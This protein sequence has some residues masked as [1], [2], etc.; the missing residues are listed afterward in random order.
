MFALED[1]TVPTAVVS[2]AAYVD[3]TAEGDDEN[4]GVFRFTRTGSTA[5]ALDVTVSFDGSADPGDDYT[6]DPDNATTVHFPIGAATADMKVYAPIDA[7][8]EDDETVVV[9]IEDY[10]PEEYEPDAEDDFATLIITDATPVITVTDT[11]DGA[12]G[13]ANG[14]FELTRTGDTSEELTVQYA[15]AGT[16]TATEGED[17]EVTGEVTFAASSATAE[18]EVVIIDDTMCDPDETAQLFISMGSN[19]AVG[20]PADD[21]ITITDD[22]IDSMF[23]P[24]HWVYW[25]GASSDV[26]SDGDNWLTGD[27]KNRVPG[28]GDVAVFDK[29]YIDE[30]GS[31]NCV[32]LEG[33]ISEVRITGGYEGTVTMTADLTVR[34]LVL[35][36]ATGT[37]D[38]PAPEEGTTDITVTGA[39]LFTAG[40]LNSTNNLATLAL[41]GA[42]ALLVPAKHVAGDA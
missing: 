2:V 29:G 32:G 21:E 37:L 19:Y 6:L 3:E 40:T 17:F 24:E 11:G 41:S 13:G 23:E 25:T 28:S 42:A 18:V 31:A 16:T 39:M 12:E 20:T 8:T 34:D 33:E 30:E 10:N 36:S 5:A 35:E 14:M 1:R 22:E 15:I 38:Q 9:A 27:S 4:S 7:Y 26:F